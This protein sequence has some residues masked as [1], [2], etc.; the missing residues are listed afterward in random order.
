MND[1]FRDELGSERVNGMV[2]HVTVWMRR[3]LRLACIFIAI[4]LVAKVTVVD[5]ADA[6]RYILI[7]CCLASVIAIRP[8]D[9]QSTFE[10]EFCL[11][12]LTNGDC[13]DTLSTLLPFAQ[14]A[15]R[16]KSKYK[17]F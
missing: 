12:P 15:N 13:R 4:C 10:N 11:F 3:R 5:D 7:G 8:F 17:L 16:K 14:L 1:V 9:D 2:E 6:V